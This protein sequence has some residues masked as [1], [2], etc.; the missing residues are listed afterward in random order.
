VIK[1][2]FLKTN[3]F[4]N[5]IFILFQFVCF[6]P[7]I[8]LLINTNRRLKMSKKSKKSANHTKSQVETPKEKQPKEVTS[9]SQAEATKQEEPLTLEGIQK[10]LN[11]LKE[12]VLSHSE[13]IAA[14][15]EASTKKRKPTSNGKIQILDKQ[16]GEVYPSK[17]QAYQTLLKSG[18][19][20]ELVDKG[21]FG[22]EPE[23]NTFG[24]YAL[25]RAWPDRFEEKKIGEVAA[26]K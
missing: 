19:L 16:T 11:S 21:V 5:K 17:N 7:T 22:S 4:L 18:E 9:K 26:S 23:K 6:Q 13:L 1:I 3:Y 15:Q 20:K 14:L 25:V 12:L 2:I 24:W 8:N 10:E